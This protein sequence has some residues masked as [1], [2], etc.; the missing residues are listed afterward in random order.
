MLGDCAFSGAFFIIAQFKGNGNWRTTGKFSF[1]PTGYCDTLNRGDI[2]GKV[3]KGQ[4]NK[5]Y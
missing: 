2:G 3:K 5:Q 1:N 4:L